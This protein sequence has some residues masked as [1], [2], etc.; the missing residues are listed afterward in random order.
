MVIIVQMASS[1]GIGRGIVV[2]VMANCA[3]IRNGC[4][5]TVERIYGIV[6][7]ESSR[8]PARFCGMAGGTGVGNAG[9]CMIGIACLI[10]V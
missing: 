9:C 6:C 5:G 3:V 4:M 8:F 7:R 2:S 1:A 10:V